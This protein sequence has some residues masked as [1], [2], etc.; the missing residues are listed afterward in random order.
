MST[1][2]IKIETT[3][4]QIEA[5]L[6]AIRAILDYQLE[7]EGGEQ[8]IHERLAHADELK[9]IS[10]LAASTVANCRAILEAQKV[11]WIESIA[12]D[13]NI[14]LSPSMAME[15]V[16]AKSGVE[17]A[18]YEYAVRLDKRIT[19]AIDLQRTAISALKEE[20]KTLP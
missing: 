2:S 18:Q 6:K 14:Q 10:G 11:H 8:Q 12:T 4:K 9:C 16:K 13:K 3:H 19:T 1:N 5:N 17:Q 20:L 7:A 15:M